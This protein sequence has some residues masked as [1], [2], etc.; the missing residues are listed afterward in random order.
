MK[1]NYVKPAIDTVE[2]ELLSII[3]SS[4][5][6]E[7]EIGNEG[8]GDGEGD[9]DDLTNHRRGSWGNLWN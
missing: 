2:V 3:A 5:L 6:N 9:G 8:T 1:R 7:G 4:G